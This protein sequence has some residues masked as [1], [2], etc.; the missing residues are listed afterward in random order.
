M[1]IDSSSA[2]HPLPSIQVR[3]PSA[4]RVSQISPARRTLNLFVLAFDPAKYT[5]FA[6]SVITVRLEWLHQ[7]IFADATVV[8]I[9]VPAILSAL[10]LVV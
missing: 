1:I 3:A 7:L 9:D 5:L 6:K 10:D 2:V 8:V 4:T